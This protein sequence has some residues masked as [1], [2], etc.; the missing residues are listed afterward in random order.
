MSPDWPIVF[1]D[2]V[3]TGRVLAT[4]DLSLLLNLIELRRGGR[5][6]SA[7]I[8]SAWRP[9]A[10]RARSGDAEH[11]HRFPSQRLTH[12]HPAQKIRILHAFPTG[13]PG[14]THT[15]IWSE[16]QLQ[17][18]SAPISYFTICS[19]WMHQ[20]PQCHMHHPK[21]TEYLSHNSLTSR[22]YRST[23]VIFKFITFTDWQLLFRFLK[24]FDCSDANHRWLFDL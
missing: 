22:C 4:A 10:G 9:A 8:Y 6:C 13:P 23:A 11:F 5:G 12:V 1:I 18:S 16:L 15:F 19:K 7:V 17:S 24:S 2:L 3:L 20:N 21:T 14:V